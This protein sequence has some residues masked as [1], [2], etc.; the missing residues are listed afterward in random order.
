MS[1]APDTPALFVL[2]SLSF[3]V[4]DNF[5]TLLTTISNLLFSCLYSKSNKAELSANFVW[6]NVNSL[7]VNLSVAVNTSLK[8]SPLTNST[9]VYKVS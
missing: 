8:V 5:S 2:F 7:I 4:F 3:I 9:S 1:K 6:F